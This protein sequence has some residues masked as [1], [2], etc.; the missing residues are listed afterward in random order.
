MFDLMLKR[1]TTVKAYSKQEEEQ[2]RALSKLKKLGISSIKEL[3]QQI[4]D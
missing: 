3:D 4:F 1:G 2:R